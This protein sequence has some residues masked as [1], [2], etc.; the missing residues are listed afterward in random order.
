MRIL[1]VALTAFILSACDKPETTATPAPTPEPE[2][3]SS[4]PEMAK[5]DTSLAGILA[6]QADEVKARYAFRHPQE[7]LEFFGIKPGMTVVE[8]LPGEGWYSQILVPYLGQQGK[9]IGQDYDSDMWKNFDWASEEFIAGRKNWPAEWVGN[10]VG[11]AN[12]KGAAASA[13]TISDTPDSLHGTVDAVLFIRALHNLHRFED[14][15]QHFTRT[16][17]KT[18]QLLKAGGVVGIVQH[19]A[20]EEK[21]DEW[22]DGSRGYLK[23]SQLV[24]KMEQA[25]FEFVAESAIN[26]NAK[27]QPGEEDIVWRLPPSLATS[28]ENEE[29]KQQLTAIGESNRMTLLFRKP[30]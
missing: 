4:A 6:A 3:T 12:G 18:L 20:P 15:G 16:L 7:T 28:K 14:K 19:E 29:L 26:T 30:L 8:V 27:D 5:P 23:K 13:F 2:K 9:L 10:A 22:A 24:A 21:T 25:G 17:A 1:I 11:W